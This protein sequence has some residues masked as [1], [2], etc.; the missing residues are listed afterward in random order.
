MEQGDFFRIEFSDTISF[1]KT[2]ENHFKK[3]NQICPKNLNNFLFQLV[4]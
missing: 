4:I 2:I 1:I 3:Y